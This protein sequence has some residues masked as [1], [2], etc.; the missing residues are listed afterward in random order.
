MTA[1]ETARVGLGAAQTV[2][3]GLGNRLGTMVRS[4]RGRHLLLID[5]ISILAA[6]YLALSMRF[7]GLLDYQTYALFLPIALIPLL[8]RPFVNLRFGLYR[9]AWAQAS[10]PDLT[11]IAWATIVGTVISMIIFFGVLEP[12]AVHGAQGFPRSFWFLEML[13]T[14]GALGASRFVI[15]ACNELGTRTVVDGATVSLTPALLFGAGRNGALMARSAMREPKAGIK[16]VGFLDN[17]PANRGATVAGLPVFGGL[18]RIDEAIRHTGAR[19]AP[20]HDAQCLGRGCPDG[21]GSS[22][23]SR[24]RRSAPCRRSTSCSTAAG[25]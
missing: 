14:L 4:I 3:I 17:D 21:H 20:D 6:S 23:R 24:P 5:M 22:H 7:D 15:R 2:T 16:P 10:V 11:Q 1:G 9:R 12:L 13:L 18:D 19:D 25:T 8:V